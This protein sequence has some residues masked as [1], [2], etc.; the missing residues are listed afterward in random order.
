M[1]ISTI[2]LSLPYEGQKELSY[3]VAC[4]TAARLLKAGNIVIAPVIAGHAME[5]EL[6][7]QVLKNKEWIRQSL[8]LLRRCNVVVVVTLP[9]W[10]ESEGVAQETQL[11]NRLDIP[12]MYCDVDVSKMETTI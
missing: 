11:A 9:G 4:F 5:T 2:F 12:V 8:E 3:K 10:E 7:R 6:G 1:N